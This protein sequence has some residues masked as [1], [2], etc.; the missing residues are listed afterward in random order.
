MCG[1]GE[2]GGEYREGKVDIVIDDA[3]GVKYLA[4]TRMVANI[5]KVKRMW[6]I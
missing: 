4:T 5:V 3:V 6:C 1:D 2:V